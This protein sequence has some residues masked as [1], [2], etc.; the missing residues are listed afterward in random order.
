M[1]KKKKSLTAKII[2]WFVAGVL[3]IAA[4]V[5]LALAF[6]SGGYVPWQAGFALAVCAYIY[7]PLA[8]APRFAQLLALA[9]A[10]VA[11]RIAASFWLSGMN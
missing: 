10:W 4:I 8:Q 3:A 2:D 6:F 5:C 7:S 1:P 9:I 11:Q